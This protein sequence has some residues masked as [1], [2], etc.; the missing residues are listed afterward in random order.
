LGRYK[1]AVVSYKQIFTAA[2]SDVAN[3]ARYLAG[4]ISQS[5]L[6]DYTAAVSLFDA[7]LNNAP[8]GAPNRAEA[9]L[10]LAESLLRLGDRARARSVLGQII[11][12]YG[13]TPIANRARE[14]LD[15]N[16]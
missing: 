11:S 16:P 13:R 3:R 2:D 6:G 9:K 5:K 15:Q 1:E 8:E 14:I 7:Y 4:E 10:R 12:E